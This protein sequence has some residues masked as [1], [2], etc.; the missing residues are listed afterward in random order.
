MTWLTTVAETLGRPNE[1][2]IFR[3]AIDVGANVP[4]ISQLDLDAPSAGVTARLPF[5]PSR[6]PDDG[7]RLREIYESFDASQ[8]VQD[9]ATL[10]G[11]DEQLARLLNGV[12]YRQNHG[13][14]SG[15]RGAGKTSLAS[16]CAER[17]RAEGVVVLYSSNDLESSFG[18]LMRQLLEQVPDSLLPQG[19]AEA[20]RRR[21]SELSSTSSAQEVANLLR[22]ISYS[23]LVMIVDEFDRVPDD[24]FKFQMAS[25]LKV[26]SDARLRAR[27]ILV[28]DERTYP[29]ILKGHASL[30]RHTSHFAVAPL[31]DKA[32]ADLLNS[33]AAAADLKFSAEALRMISDVVCGSPYHARLF[34]LHAA[35][36]AHSNGS[37]CIRMQ[38]AQSGLSEAFLEWENINPA[39]A[40]AFRSAVANAGVGRRPMLTRLAEDF[41]RRRLHAGSA[42]DH[43]PGDFDQLIASLGSAVAEGPEG[44]ILKDVTAAQFLLALAVTH[45]RQ[46]SADVPQKERANS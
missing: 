22:R 38:D 42:S 15:P 26:T 25:L 13:V 2:R 24:A 36:M 16:I 4:P 37:E 23:S 28:G 6:P 44:P 17:A 27:F 33:C 43:P 29:D 10:F 5:P 8:P 19:E 41:A 7:E 1:W 32:I 40:D 12:L 11:R 20:F 3:P 30:A 21:V 45:E 39:D 35:L 46:R 9:P 18:S 31:P 34:G 14:I